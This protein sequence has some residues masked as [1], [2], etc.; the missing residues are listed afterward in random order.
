[1][2]TLPVQHQR[3]QASGDADNN[4]EQ[5][6]EQ[7]SIVARSNHALPFACASRNSPGFNG[8]SSSPTDGTGSDLPRQ[9]A[10]NILAQPYNTPS[11]F[12]QV[13]GQSNFVARSNWVGIHALPATRAPRDVRGRVLD[14]KFRIS[15][16]RP[17]NA[18]GK[19]EVAVRLEVSLWVMHAL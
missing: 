6:H 1:M 16:P 10:A 19:Y 17:G 12:E 5:V 2:P 3:H 18:S 13:H 11:A 9:T 8:H 7:R 14:V 15:D 4:S